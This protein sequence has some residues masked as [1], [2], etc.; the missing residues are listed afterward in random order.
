MAAQGAGAGPAAQGAGAGA[1]DPGTLIGT[2]STNIG[3]L[4]NTAKALRARATECAA[5]LEA[6]TAQSTAKDAQAVGLRE[7][8][9][10]L[11]SGATD[12]QAKLANIMGLL[13]TLNATVV[14]GKGQLQAGGYRRR[15][16]VA[17]KPTK[18]RAKTPKRKTRKGKK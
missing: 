14:S 2:I 1:P 12:A 17:R 11:E 8:I 3:E 5:N 7:T 9:T 6:K 4:I 15:R 16:R 10:R 18:K 13:Q